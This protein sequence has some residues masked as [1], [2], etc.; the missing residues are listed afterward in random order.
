MFTTVLYEL[1]SKNI[2]DRKNKVAI[3]DRENVYTY[4]QI[5]RKVDALAAWMHMRGVRRGHRVGI[6]L[7]KSIEE[8]IAI[9]AVAKLG[10]VIVNVNYQWTIKQFEYVVG[11]CNISL[12]IL[13]EKRAKELAE[14]GKPK[15]I[16]TI[17]VNGNAPMA[18]GYYEWKDLPEA[19]EIYSAPCIDFD[20]AAIL[21]TSGSTGRPKGV[22][23]T[24]LNIIQGARSV[25]KYLKNRSEDRVISV[26]PFSFDYG[27]NQLTT[28]FLVGGTLILH[29]ITMPSEIIQSIKKH[30]VTG[31]AAVP[32]T[33]VG[34]VRYLLEVPNELPSLRYITN[35]GGKIS[36]NILQAFPRVFPG[37]EVFLMYGLTESFR[38]TYLPPTLF[39]KKMGSIGKSI[40]NAETFIIR[41]DGDGICGPGEE[42]EL[43]HRG[44]LVSKGYWEKPEAT[45]AKIKSCPALKGI[46]GD[47]K[48]VYSGDIIRIDEDGYYWFV[49]RIDS[50]IKCSGF[51]ISPQE[52]EEIVLS[53]NNISEVVAFGQDDENL[54]QVVNVV[55]ST[56]DNEPLDTIQFLRL[57]RSSMPHYMI[58]KIIHQHFGKMPKTSSGK[59]DVPKVVKKYIQ[60]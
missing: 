40:P 3:I 57:C 11:D 60:K 35:S 18:D 1:L 55:V 23:L 38:S 59:I 8:V 30:K 45:K 4:E 22:M 44:T 20:L 37:V 39:E 32:P 42:G 21:Y 28:M 12:A 10:G 46:I 58:P 56:I 14:Y 17:L 31:F 41:H 53:F 50:L 54:G 16:H 9:F 5:T 7:Y 34:I 24:H 6:Y 51:R 13:D 29:A 47:E 15:F 33:W 27:L 2:P 26:L 52:V 19:V 49:G 36:G 48:V 43:V 25:G